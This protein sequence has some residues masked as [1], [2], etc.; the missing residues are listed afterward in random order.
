MGREDNLYVLYLDEL[1]SNNVKCLSLCMDENY[2][3]YERLWDVGMD[4]LRR[5]SSQDLVRGLSKMIFQKNITL[6]C[7]P[8]WKTNQNIFQTKENGFY[9]KHLELVH[10][11][12]SLSTFEYF[13]YW[14]KNICF[15]YRWW[16]PKV[17][18]GFISF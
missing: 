6:P 17:Y 11:D 13:E 10:M 15:C 9:S 12:R 4:L 16:F 2:W 1:I 8:I 14:R 5:L 3:W 18:L 7:F